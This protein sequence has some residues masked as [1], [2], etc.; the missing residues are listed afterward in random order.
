MALVKCPDCGK[1]VSSRA[2]A[3]PECG[4]PAEYFEENTQ[5]DLENKTTLNNKNHEVTNVNTIKKEAPKEFVLHVRKKVV[6]SYNRNGKCEKE[7][8]Y[9]KANLY[10]LDISDVDRIYTEAYE[11]LGKLNLYLDNLYNE[12]HG[13]KLSKNQKAEFVS[14]GNSLLLEENDLTNFNEAYYK[15]NELDLKRKFLE[16]L[17]EIY[18]EKGI[19]DRRV[20]GKYNHLKSIQAFKLFEEY[21]KRIKKMEVIIEPEYE[22]EKLLELSKDKIKMIRQRALEFHF[23]GDDIDA[24]VCGYEMKSGIYAK[25][26]QKEAEKVYLHVDAQY[27]CCYKIFEKEIRFDGRYFIRYGIATLAYQ[28]QDAFINKIKGKDYSNAKICNLFEQELESFKVSLSNDVQSLEKLLDFSISDE[29]AEEINTR[30]QYVWD[31]IGELDIDLTEIALDKKLSKEERANIKASRGRWVGGGFGVKGAVKGAVTAGAMNAATGLLYS[32]ANLV[33]NAVSSVIASHKRK[34]RIEEFI[35][36]I[37]TGTEYSCD[38]IYRE[39]WDIIREYYPKLNYVPD[40]HDTEDEKELRKQ[41][42]ACDNIKDK[43]EIAHTLLLKN[44]YNPLNGLI[45]FLVVMNNDK[46]SSREKINGIF[47]KMTTKFRWSTNLDKVLKETNKKAEDILNKDPEDKISDESVIESYGELL[48]ILELC[49]KLQNSQEKQSETQKTIKRN[50]EFYNKLLK[51]QQYVHMLR[52]ILNMSAEQILKVGEEYLE[53]KEYFKAQLIYTKGAYSHSAA[54]EIIDCFFA[55]KD[56]KKLIEL[57]ES[58]VD[59]QSKKG[60][61]TY[62]KMMRIFAGMKNKENKTLLLYAAELHNRKMVDELINYNANVD[63]LY[64][65]IGKEKIK[66]ETKEKNV[67]CKSCGRHLSDNA[68]FCNFC[69]TKVE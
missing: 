60:T 65:L 47:E 42:C 33:G 19:V 41:Y 49:Q 16:E 20:I 52:D 7:S 68:K 18:E 46:N 45:V 9:S 38:S 53:Q 61:I 10:G 3:C 6:E 14:F 2:L 13:L 57:L 25:R 1:L 39:C 26:L 30:L 31:A 51:K 15:K 56:S 69:G 22:G 28:A 67:F 12:S 37:E 34:K 62:E 66:T 63:L 32:G 8:F 4:C 44:P 23:V 54:K 58:F 43:E 40:Y 11:I 55:G 35:D 36:K 21:E 27:A 17:L 29:L 64:Q 59:K 24:L 5:L 50:R 48:Y